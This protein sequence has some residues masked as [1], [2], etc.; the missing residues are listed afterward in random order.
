MKSQIDAFCLPSNNSNIFT[1]GTNT[2][3][4]SADLSIKGG[5]PSAKLF[6]SNIPIDCKGMACD[7]SGNIW[8]HNSNSG[9][10]IK[11]DK[12]N[13]NSLIEFEGSSNLHLGK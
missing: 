10:L 13:L 2:T 5:N 4:K 9:K 3:I 1:L 8:V 6:E 11:Y 12:N 7:A